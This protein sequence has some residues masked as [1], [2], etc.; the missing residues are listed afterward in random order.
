MGSALY[1][2]ITLFMWAAINGKRTATFLPGRDKRRVK[3]S[4]AETLLYE[5]PEIVVYGDTGL[6]DV[7]FG[8][9]KFLKHCQPRV[10]VDGRLF[11]A[12]SKSKR[13]KLIVVNVE[14]GEPG[15]SELGQVTETTI[16]YTL[17]D[18]GKQ[19]IGKIYQGVNEPFIQFKL[20][21]PW[22]NGNAGTG[23]FSNPQ[24]EF[25][26]F[27]NENDNA[28]VLT[29]ANVKFAPPRTDFNFAS[30]PVILY[31]DELNAF[32]FSTL[33]HFLVSGIKRYKKQRAMSCG[34]A[35]SVE[36]TPEGFTLESMVFFGKGINAVVE[37]WGALFRKRH[38]AKI[39]DPYNNPITSTLGYNTDN[40]AFYYYNTEPGKNYEDT[41]IAIREQHKKIGLPVGYYELDSWWYPKSYEKLPSILK[42]FVSGS[43]LHWGEPPKADVFPNGLKNTWENLDK[44][45]LM[46][47][48]RWFSPKS[49]YTQKYEF[50]IQKPNLKTF[51]LP[52]FAAPMHQ[53][54]WDDLFKDARD[55]GL[56]CYLQDWM[57]YQYNSIDK[58]KSSVDFADAWAMNMGKAA[59]KHGM[60]MQYCMAPSSFMMQAVKLPSVMQTR[61]SDDHNGMQ[62]RRWYLPHFTQTSM[63]CHA[64]G[65]WPS[66]DTFFS[67]TEKV[68]WFYRERCPEM[69]CLVAALSGGP[70]APS[71][72][73]GFENVDLLMKT[74]RADGLL[75]KPDKPAT[76]VD[77]MFKEHAKYYITS[78][79]VKKAGGLTW[80]YVH[81]TNLWPRKVK[82]KT[83]S[84]QD[85][86]IDGM[87]KYMAYLYWKKEFIPMAYPEDKITLDLENEAQE[88]IVLCPELAE[89]TFLIGNIEKFVTCAAKQFPSV[90]FSD[91]ASTV[92]IRVEGVSGEKVPVSFWF[93][94]KIPTVVFPETSVQV[95]EPNHVMVVT[96]IMD[97][98]GKQDIEIKWPE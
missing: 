77:L 28:H 9:K 57:S 61:A 46:C 91:D 51:N 84:L 19:V 58:M 94:Q 40:G 85:L 64:I 95:D 53:D 62:P 31:D 88:L 23:K 74:C 21:L 93:D 89:G 17:G 16:E 7:K 33:D 50:Y 26:W 45:P 8:E 44:L 35:G 36:K 43:A 97:D 2:Q 72:K 54:F 37:A 59:E 56:R 81:V 66:K 63:L 73:I 67:N 3:S 18:T 38:G 39:R 47:H 90:D 76:P 60:T 1:F 98:E 70:V 11:T 25:P 30:A 65:F 15:T 32:A 52:L 68:Y 20:V 86:G 79:H 29:W 87:H 27:V 92:T 83:I 14:E 10:L 42:I 4:K 22:E 96:A 78:T 75:L 34:L 71:D 49:D 82:D 12:T 80:H 13:S 69:E 5:K 41:M 48:S 24:I 6:F 55:W